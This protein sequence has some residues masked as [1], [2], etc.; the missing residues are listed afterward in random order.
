MGLEFPLEKGIAF[1]IGKSHGERSLE[2]YSP[3]GQR[4]LAHDLATKQPSI[5]LYYYVLSTIKC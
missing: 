3:W 4:R 5:A 1:L 2:G